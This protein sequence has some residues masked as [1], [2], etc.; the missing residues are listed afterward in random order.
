MQFSPITGVCAK[1]PALNIQHITPSAPTPTVQAGVVAAADKKKKT[2]ST[3]FRVARRWNMNDDRSTTISYLAGEIAGVIGNPNEMERVVCLT[4]QPL[5]EFLGGW[6]Q[7]QESIKNRAS[8]TV[9]IP[10]ET[11]ETNITLTCDFGFF[12]NEPYRYGMKV[13]IATA[14]STSSTDVNAECSTILSAEDLD[15]I[16]RYR[17][18]MLQHIEFLQEN[19]ECYQIMRREILNNI[20]LMMTDGDGNVEDCI[21]QM[22]SLD[23]K[24]RIIEAYKQECAV[25]KLKCGLNMYALLTYCLGQPATLKREWMEWMEEEQAML[26]KTVKKLDATKAVTTVSK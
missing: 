11:E 25:K 2:W 4:E 12:P 21:E 6:E 24:K 26:M 23:S 9:P 3:A 17:R 18:Y 8:F 14:A 10:N 15:L 1:R 7:L 22:T 19:M 16:S 20:Q 13:C 5:L